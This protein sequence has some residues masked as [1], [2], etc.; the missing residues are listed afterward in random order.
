MRSL[1]LTGDRDILTGLRLAGIVGTYCPD[2]KAL[3]DAFHKALE[4]PEIGL[5][6]LTTSGFQTLKE[7]V[8]EIKRF[9]KSPLVVTIP[10]FNG[11][12]EEN[13]I[14]K[15]IQ[16][17]IGVGMGDDSLQWY[18]LKKRWPFSRTWSI[19]KKKMKPRKK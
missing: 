12:V 13:F 11:E 17:S 8:I 5:I 19:P 15:Y 14:L 7:E 3:E 18:I 6:L 2:E 16:E 4:D 9:R 1:A 10:D